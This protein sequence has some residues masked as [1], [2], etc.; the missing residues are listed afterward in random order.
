M[1]RKIF[2]IDIATYSQGKTSFFALPWLYLKKKEFL[3][4]TLLGNDFIRLDL[5]GKICVN[6]AIDMFLKI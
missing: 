5:R 4:L 2:K 6:W 1:E 3:F